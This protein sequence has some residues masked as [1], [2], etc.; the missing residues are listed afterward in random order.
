MKILKENKMIIYTIIIVLSLSIIETII[1][2]IVPLKEQTNQIISF[3]II[4]IYSFILGY[5]T[6]LHTNKKGYIEGLKTSLKIIITIYTLGIIT[7]SFKITLKRLIYFL[8]II[9]TT[10]LGS[11]IGINKKRQ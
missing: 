11:I 6:G 7:M 2:L 5:N 9:L 3:I 1:N 8:L 10:T 4:N